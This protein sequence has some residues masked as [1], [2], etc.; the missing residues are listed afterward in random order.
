M[1]VFHCGFG[2]FLYHNVTEPRQAA[3]YQVVCILNGKRREV[4]K[5]ANPSNAQSKEGDDFINVVFELV[6][7][8]LLQ[9]YF[10]SSNTTHLF[11]VLFNPS[12]AIL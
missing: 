9:I 10:L 4:C 1:W 5:N 6:V 8:Y 11:T 12:M 3:Q 2:L 7:S